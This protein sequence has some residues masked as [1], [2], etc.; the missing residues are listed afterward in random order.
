MAAIVIDDWD[1]YDDGIDEG[2]YVDDYDD[3]EEK[4]GV[5]VMEYEVVETLYLVYARFDLVDEEFVVAVVV[6]ENDNDGFVVVALEEELSVTSQLVAVMISWLH[7]YHRNVEMMVLTVVALVVVMKRVGVEMKCMSDV[8]VVD[9]FENG[10]DDFVVYENDVND[11]D[12]IDVL[13][14]NDEYEYAMMMMMMKRD[15]NDGDDGDAG[16][17]WEVKL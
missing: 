16:I 3:R 8:E 10:N 6:V 15:D 9:L 2:D 14:G 1:Y 17:A 5:T 7:D 13:E 4:V 11:Y 12:E